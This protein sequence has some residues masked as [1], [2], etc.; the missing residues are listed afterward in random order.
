MLW[1]G[2]PPASG[3]TTVAR[4]LARRHGLRLYS[5]D[6]RTWVH[7]DR[8]LEA[9]NA[10]AA[11]W[12]S[13]TPTT[14]WEH[15]TPKELLEMSLHRERGAMVIDD[16]QAMPRSPLIIAEGSPLPASAVSSGTATRA[17]SVWLLPTPEFQEASLA[18][19]ETTGGRAELYRRLRQVIT[20]EAHDHDVRSLTVDGS[21]RASEIASLVEQMFAGALRAGPC[22]RTPAERQ[23]LSREMNDAVVEQVRGYFARPWAEGDPEAV[24]Q[25]FV[26]ECGDPGCDTELELAVGELPAHRAGGPRHVPGASTTMKG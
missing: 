3:K 17:G 12:E 8:A 19:T 22:A 23:A 9:G 4:L 18:A 15:V 6:T 13:L 7:R 1:I 26:C 11:R 25:S 21:K 24:R 10:A 14:R 16:L 2:G 5:A 20:S